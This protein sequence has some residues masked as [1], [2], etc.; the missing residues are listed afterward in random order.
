M[1]KS[2]IDWKGRGGVALWYPVRTSDDKKLI[3]ELVP[4]TGFSQTA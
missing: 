2:D 1:H 3:N 4:E